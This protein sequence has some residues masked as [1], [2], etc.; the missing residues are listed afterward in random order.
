MKF[1]T[2]LIADD[3]VL[4]VRTLE[5]AFIEKNF[6]VYTANNGIDALKQFYD[7][8]PKIILMDIDMPE[9]N[10]WEVLKQI[11]QENRLIPII[12]MTGQYIEEA[13]AIKSF[14]DG[15]TSFIRKSLSY[16]EIIASVDS[17]FRLTCSPDE[18]FSFGKFT[19]NM[20]SPYLQTG[21]EKYLL[22]D[23]EA[24]LLCLLVK[25]I[26]Q[27]VNIKKILHSIWGNDSSSN[28]QMMRNT[29]VKLNRLFEKFEKIQIKSI[30]GVGYL[31]QFKDIQ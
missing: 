5:K 28:N 26:N 18:I 27:T 3:D 13:D 7:C 15:A 1:H 4:L 24:Q 31:L 9:K 21:N 2:I 25:N 22:T 10:G 11:R 6:H 30:Y 20:S 16:K 12:I 23:R 17:L 19:L 29:I 8:K 14:D